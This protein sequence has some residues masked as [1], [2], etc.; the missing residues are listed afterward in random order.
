MKRYYKKLESKLCYSNMNLDKYNTYLPCFLFN[1]YAFIKYSEFLWS[2][3]T[4][5]LNLVAFIKYLWFS[6]FLITANI[7]LL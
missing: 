2:I 5:N 3:Q 7:S 6:N 4:L 1:F